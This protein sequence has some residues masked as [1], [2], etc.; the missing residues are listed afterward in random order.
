M[1]TIIKSNNIKKLMSRKTP[2]EMAVVKTGGKQYLVYPGLALKVEKMPGKYKVGDKIILA[3]VL[4]LTNKEIVVGR[5][6]KTGK[7]IKDT[8]NLFH[9]HAKSFGLLLIG[10]AILI[11]IQS[12]GLQ[13]LG[14]RLSGEGFLSSISSPVVFFVIVI[15]LMVWWVSSK[16]D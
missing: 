5:D 9:K 2:T 8:E 13:L 14:I 7:L 4:G 6:E 11:F 15:A 12:G 3:E 1:K 16:K 10:I